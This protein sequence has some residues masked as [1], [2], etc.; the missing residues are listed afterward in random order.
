MN[1]VPRQAMSVGVAT[2]T[3]AREVMILAFGSK[4][5][6]AIAQSIEGPLS[7]YCTV[8]ALQDHE[9]GWIVC[10]EQACGELKVN[11]YKYFKALMDVENL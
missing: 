10:D 1:Q 6:R 11:S 4:K 3:G 2:V 5:A 8:S 9:N 7:H